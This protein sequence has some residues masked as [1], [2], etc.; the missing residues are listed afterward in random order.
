V[1]RWGNDQHIQAAPGGYEMTRKKVGSDIPPG[2][3]VEV[4]KR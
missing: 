4:V 2:Q 3:I 1:R